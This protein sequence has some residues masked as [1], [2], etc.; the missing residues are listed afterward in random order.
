MSGFENLP[1]RPKGNTD[2]IEAKTSEIKD[3]IL[4]LR[5]QAD[6]LEQNIEKIAEA[7]AR[8]DSKK[9]EAERA[10]IKNEV[11]A[12]RAQ[13]DRLEQNIEKIAEARAGH[14]RN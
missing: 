5:T 11:L 8:G 1:Q 13:A 3:E 14:D 7:R 6:K 2:K 9:V 4:T 12:L 10:G